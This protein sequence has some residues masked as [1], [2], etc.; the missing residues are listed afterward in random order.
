MSFTFQLWDVVV[1]DLSCRLP[2]SID[3]FWLQLREGKFVR[4][5]VCLHSSVVGGGQFLDQHVS[6][7]QKRY[8]SSAGDTYLVRGIKSTVDNEYP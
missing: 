4:N 5:Y 1:N 6:A 3:V 7:P 2:S 8:M